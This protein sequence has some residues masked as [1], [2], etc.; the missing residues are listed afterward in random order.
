[1]GVAYN[2][3][4]FAQL[5]LDQLIWHDVIAAGRINIPWHA[6]TINERRVLWHLERRH[7][8]MEKRIKSNQIKISRARAGRNFYIRPP[9]DRPSP[10]RIPT[11]AEASVGN[12][13][14]DKSLRFW[15][16][17][18]ASFEIIRP[19]MNYDF[20]FARAVNELKPNGIQMFQTFA[21]GLSGFT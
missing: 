18:R 8:E 6:I 9:G 17:S 14:A 5:A 7:A 11:H 3:R 20:P 4:L 12:H 10:R 16:T 21:I 15:Q 19:R 2:G 1:M 13:A